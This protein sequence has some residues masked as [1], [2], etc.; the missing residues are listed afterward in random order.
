MHQYYM[1]I[2]CI[3]RNYAN[4]AKELNNPIPKEPMFFL[5]PDTALIPNKNPFF[6]PDFSNDI[7]YEVEL[8]VRINKLGKNIEEQF[9]HRYYEEIGIGVDFTA[10]DVQQHCKEKGHPW[11][12]AKAFDGSAPVSKQFISVSK[13]DLDKGI[14]FS[15]TR[16][17]N[18]VQEGNSSDMI[19]SINKIIAYVSKF[20]TLKI[21]DLIFTGTPEGVGKVE[22]GDLLEA[23]IEGEKLLEVKVR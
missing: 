3:G 13:L 14:N 20:I 18:L 12:K 19:F 1:K 23:S 21:G 11:E 16:N 4:H 22:K 2:I 9:A 15:L 6:I 10:R 5:K 8:V 7:H 17:G